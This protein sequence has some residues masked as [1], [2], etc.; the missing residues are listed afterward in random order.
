MAAPEPEHTVIA[1][2]S[3]PG[4]STSAVLRLSGP[5]ALDAA[6]RLFEPAYGAH[7]GVSLAGARPF[8]VIA[9]SFEQGGFAIPSSLVLFRGPRSYTGEDMVEITIPG[10]PPVVQSVLS[11]FLSLPGSDLR[12]ARP[13]E[14]TYRA[15][16]SGRIDLSQAEA[17]AALI[18]ACSEE[19]SRAAQRQLR[20][21]LAVRVQAI[22]NDL[23]AALAL[24]EAALDFPDEDLPSIA[25]PAIRERIDPAVA[26]IDSLRS[27]S[28][29]RLSDTGA[30]RVVLAGFP[31]AG[32]SSLLN[33]LLGRP[34]AIVADVAGTTRDP[35]RGSTTAPGRRPIE[36]VDVAGFDDLSPLVLAVAAGDRKTAATCSEDL[37]ETIR[38]LTETELAAADVV[39]WV[40]DPVDRSTC[41]RSLAAFRG[42]PAPRKVLVAA[43]ADLLSEDVQ[44]LWRDLPECPV[45]LSSLRGRGLEDLVRRVEAGEGPRETPQFF[46]TARQDGALCRARDLSSRAREALGGALG[47]EFVAVDLREAVLALEEITGR[48]IGERILEAIFGRFCIGK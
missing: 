43:K 37:S 24:I 15:F 29:L 13:G 5:C 38:R 41:E 27:A 6:S 45:V 8:T 19:E 21:E 3:A 31:N 28:A 33:A 1:V 10:S 16:R 17:V 34:A 26:A 23:V 14:F 35:V 47:Y 20:G 4:A 18:G 44:R 46:L 30:L 11:A 9:G 39:V 42:L 2:A 22:A 7:E 40:V 25:P 32:K 48:E 12:L 36:W